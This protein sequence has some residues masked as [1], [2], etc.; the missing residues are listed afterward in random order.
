MRV[1]ISNVDTP[2]GHN[3]S[4]IISRTPVGSRRDANDDDEEDSGEEEEEEEE[5]EKESEKVDVNDD[6]KGIYEV[7][8]T[9]SHPPISEE[10]KE[11][12][13]MIFPA[14]MVECGDKNIDTQRR[15]AIE[16]YAVLGEKPQWV[17]EIVDNS[18]LDELYK[19]LVT[20]DIIIY[21]ITTCMDEALYIAEKFHKDAES[22]YEH[23]KIFIAVSSIMTWA[24]T[25]VEDENLTEDEYRRRRAHPNFR[26]L[27]AAEKSIVKFG[28]KSSF[29]TYIVVPGLIYHSGDSIFHFLFKK[30]WHNEK[31]LKCF[32]DG[33]NILPT[34]YLNDLANIIVDVADNPPDIKVILAVDDS[35][36]SL[37]EIVK[38]I[39]DSL[40]TG[41][42]E[43]IPKENAFLEPTMSQDDF[44]M[45]Q[46]NLRVEPEK[47]KEMSFEWKY[48]SGIVENIQQIINEYKYARGLQP[49]KIGIHGPPYS[50]KTTLAKK[51]AEYYRIHY[52]NAEQELKEG[53]EKLETIV[54]EYTEGSE[55]LEDY[56]NAK[57]LLDEIQEYYKANGKYSDKHYINFVRD[58]LMSMP[59]RNQGY[60]L[61]E[62]PINT[63]LVQELFK[64]LNEDDENEQYNSLIFPSYIFSL[65]AS[66]NYVKEK[67]MLLSEQQ[68]V[69]TANTEEEFTK[70][71]EEFKNNN[72][73]ENTILN[74]FDEFEVNAITLDVENKSVDY[75][76]EKVINEVGRPHNY[77]PTPE[78]IAERRRIAEEKKAKEEELAL[79]ERIKN[80]KEEEIRL[81]KERA[82]WQIK[83]EEVRKQEQ[84]VLEVQSIPLR[85]Y[86]MKYVMPTLTSGL[87]DICKIRPED[88]IDYLAEYLFKNN[89]TN[90]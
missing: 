4:R 53:V 39:S 1:F 42:V 36:N 48:E 74:Y 68:V 63:N 61:D 7:I 24:R 84:E 86:L 27:L 9:L 83:L 60:V 43:M 72:T 45:L 2:I 14:P 21:D 3:V 58:R 11:V 77:G 31:S 34:I 18:D 87:I 79:Q 59:C 13:G 57:D 47:V 51:I 52:V 75:L 56:E 22:F 5:K 25:K 81:L 8:G 82:E 16:N 33:S 89:P 37:Y 44:N 26:N 65:N 73:E 28:K 66:D 12:K 76:M 35:K 90:N 46:L 40:T 55:G 15:E 17:T 67:V 85:N 38:A 50:G 19:I 29:K 23:P 10:D 78:E 69:G 20:C 88:P 32:E 64:S 54:N 49:L 70:R 41:E 62:F 6:K 71:L 80:E 30:A